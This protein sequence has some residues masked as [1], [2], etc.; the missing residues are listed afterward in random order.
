MTQLTHMPHAVDST[1]QRRTLARITGAAGLTTVV[2]VLG[3]SIAND[4]Q[5]A[6]FT[7]TPARP[8]RSFVPSTTHS[9]RSRRSRPPSG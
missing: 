8:S 9:E 5:G 6:S 7:A 2:V 4:Y 1:Q 3:G